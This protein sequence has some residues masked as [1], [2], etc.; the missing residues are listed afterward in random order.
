M[1]TL[2]LAACV[3]IALSTCGT[4]AD[5]R[6][7]EHQGTKRIPGLIS[8]HLQPTTYRSG[9]PGRTI[10]WHDTVCNLSKTDHTWDVKVWLDKPIA[11]T[12]APTSI[13]VKAGH[14]YPKDLL[15]TNTF[16]D[17]PGDD[18]TWVNV[19]TGPLTVRRTIT[20][21]PCTHHPR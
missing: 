1:K 9:P 8:S 6:V 20:R 10:R 5:A 17:G 15:F 16:T 7:T 2:L 3:S 21:C 11:T 4:P 12:E 14:C 13:T 18:E 19:T